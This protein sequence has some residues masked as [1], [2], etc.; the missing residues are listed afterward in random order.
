MWDCRLTFSQQVQSHVGNYTI[1]EGRERQW[2]RTRGGKKRILTIQQS[3]LFSHFQ[4]TSYLLIWFL[5]FSVFETHLSPSSIT[6]LRSGFFLCS[7]ETF[8]LCLTLSV[9]LNKSLGGASLWAAVP[10][11]TMKCWLLSGIQTEAT[12]T[13]VVPLKSNIDVC[14]KFYALLIFT[15]SGF[16][17]FLMVQN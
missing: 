6:Q 4:H 16:H 15:A 14:C 12:M 8:F 3:S 10:L 2:G 5:F 13:R 11:M 7:C 9:Q 1:Q 17:C